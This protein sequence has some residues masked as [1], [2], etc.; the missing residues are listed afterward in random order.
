IGDGCFSAVTGDQY[1]GL[2]RSLRRVLGPG[3]LVL[4][5][6]FTR[7]ERAEPPARVFS[8]LAAGRIGNFHVFK[9]R[10]A[11]GLHGTLASGVRRADIWD[12][13]RAAI[14]SPEALARDRGWPLPV[15]QTIDD[16]RGLDARYSF[17]TLTEAR[18]VLAEGFTE[19]ACH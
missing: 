13:W 5:R 9:W 14:A 15:V 19:S 16:F 2:A 17:P 7:P 3:G 18:D 11:V 8:D 6:F 4:M 10:R 1:E 12:A